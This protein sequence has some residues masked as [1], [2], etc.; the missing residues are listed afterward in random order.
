M[1]A[2]ARALGWTQP[3]VSKHVRRLE[4]DLGLPL[5]VRVGRGLALTDAGGLLLRYADSLAAGLAAADDAMTNLAGIRSGLVRLAAFPS[6]SATIVAT[7]VTAL[8]SAH[9]GLDVRLTQVEPPE[10]RSLLT[11]GEVDIAVVFDYPDQPHRA[12]HA[13]MAS[14]PLMHDDLRIVVPAGHPI[15]DRPVL[16]LSDLAAERWIAGCPNCRQYLLRSAARA[17]FTPDIR[18][19]TDDYVVVQALVAAGVAVAMLPGLALAASRRSDIRDLPLTDHPPRTVD[20]E[21][22]ANTRTTPALATALEHLTR[23]AHHHLPSRTEERHGVAPP[24][25][26]A[27]PRRVDRSANPT[28]T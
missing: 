17:G 26:A 4:R 14:V 7:A 12:A 9:P 27:V 15:S 8:A 6:A 23:A 20:A 10:A 1:A 21:M 28:A 13:G 3:A 2:A 24:A 22:H 19:S 11:R 5:T 16:S 18:H 25:P